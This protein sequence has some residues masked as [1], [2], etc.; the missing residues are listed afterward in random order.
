MQTYLQLQTFLAN[1]FAKSFPHKKYL[2]MLIT[3]K[4]GSKRNT[5]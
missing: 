2:I 4:N 3:Q 1:Y 5:D